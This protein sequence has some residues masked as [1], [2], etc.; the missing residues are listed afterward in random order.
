[1]KRSVKCV[2]MLLGLLLI[3]TSIKLNA[4]T[5]E[6][7][8]DGQPQLLSFEDVA[9]PGIARMTRIQGIV[10]VKAELDENG[11][12]LAASTLAG[13]KPLIS[14]CL[15]NVKKWKFKPNSNKSAI[16][17]Y[18]FKLDEGA[19]HDASHSLFRLVHSNFATVTACTPVVR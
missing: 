3:H 15:A 17:V 6:T 19:C 1:M 2:Q 7:E 13:P 11:N 10:V 18:Q 12:V 8:R 5:A 4:Q 9:Y 16:I 14:D